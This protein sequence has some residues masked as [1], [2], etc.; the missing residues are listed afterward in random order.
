MKKSAIAIFLLV[1]IGT[2]LYAKIEPAKIDIKTKEISAWEIKR[3]IFGVFIEFL[4][5]FINFP[6]GMW[7]QELVNRGFDMNDINQNGCSEY[8]Q[9]YINNKDGLANWSLIEGGYNENGRYAQRVELLS[10]NATAGVTQTIYLNDSVSH[11]FYVYHKGEINNGELEIKIIDTLSGLTLF[12]KGLGVP[13]INWQ[14][15]ELVIP[16]LKNIHRAKILISMSNPGYV[17]ID[18]ASLMP[19]NNIFGVRKEFYD[20]YKEMKAGS[21][22]YPG[23]WFAD[24]KAGRFL[25]SIGHIDKRKSPNTAMNDIPQRMDF[26]TDEFIHFCKNLNIE[27]HITV[28]YA[29]G[30][31]QEAANWVEYCNG[32]ELTEYGDLR[33][34]NGNPKPYNVHYWEVGNEQWGDETIMAKRYLEYYDT[35]KAIDPTIKIII[36]GNHWQGYSN[37]EKLMGIVQN[38]CQI[39]GWHPTQVVMAN[40]P[41]DSILYLA[42]AGVAHHEDRT[43]QN[44]KH[45]IREWNLYPD[46]KLGLTEWWSD[47][48]ST[49]D[50]LLDTNYRNSSVE[51]ALWNAGVINAMIRHS[52][53]VVIGERT[54]GLGLLRGRINNDSGERFFYGTTNYWALSMLS[55]YSGSR[56]IASNTDCSLYSIAKHWLFDIPTL[57]AVVTTDFDS[58]YISVINRLASDSVMLKI[59]KDISI[60]ADSIVAYRLHSEHYLDANTDSNPNKILPQ[61]LILKNDGYCLLPPYSLTILAYPVKG[62]IDSV[63]P[64]EPFKSNIFVSPMPFNDYFLIDKCQFVRAGAEITL[65]DIM[66]NKLMEKVL[67]TESDK[68]YFSTAHLAQGAYFLVVRFNNEYYQKMIMKI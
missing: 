55:N 64:R 67:E 17:I 60:P 62:L 16:P 49:E 66:G 5:W 15:S 30:N 42:M 47:Y 35:M 46:V 6:Q 21:L 11:I 43:I 7:S 2:Y 22:R 50:W 40:E 38:K 14:R 34:K 13:D 53:L 39:F 58:L 31:P 28:N 9:P 68:Y 19:S 20:F 37:F 48:G 45:W 41:S 3:E 33:A 44:Y 61:K 25:H 54:A 32:S 36:D 52:D 18:E 51:S 56:V 10:S 4:N 12:S 63:S 59:E 27:P 23:G 26:G 65:F 24:S 57:D 8:W 29:E 1:F